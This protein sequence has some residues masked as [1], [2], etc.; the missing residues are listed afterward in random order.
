MINRTLIPSTALVFAAGF[1]DG[2][3]PAAKPLSAEAYRDGFS[4]EQFVG[5][6][7][8]GAES[9]GIGEIQGRVLL[10]PGQ[11]AHLI[12]EAGGFS[13]IGDKAIAVPWDQIALVNAGTVR[14]SDVVAEDVDHYRAFADRFEDRLEQRPFRADELMDDFVKTADGRDLGIVHDLIF[15]REGD[16][17]G[18]VVPPAG[19]FPTASSLTWPFADGGDGAGVDPADD[20]YR[21]PKM[22][23]EVAVEDPFPYRDW[24]ESCAFAP[25]DQPQGAPGT[26]GRRTRPPSHASGAISCVN[27]VL[28]SRSL[29]ATVMTSLSPSMST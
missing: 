19:R 3:E 4:A 24:L 2:R 28:P 12:V 13:G 9:E 23:D 7:V 8:V 29:S 17:G 22:D 18:I 5:D 26:T 1:A 14:A 25:R 16:F 27:S 21:V 15:D 11:I 6:D 20:T 10:S